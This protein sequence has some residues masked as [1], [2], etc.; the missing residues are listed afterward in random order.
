MPRQTVRCPLCELDDIHM[1]RFHKMLKEFT[2]YDEELKALV[3]EQ[4]NG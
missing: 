3:T 1:I 2:E 4:E